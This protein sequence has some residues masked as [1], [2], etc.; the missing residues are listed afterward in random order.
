VHLIESKLNS[1]CAIGN[2]TFVITP[3]NNFSRL[4]F[5]LGK[6]R[7]FGF[8]VNLSIATNLLQPASSIGKLKKT[9]I[10]LIYECYELAENFL[11]VKNSTELDFHV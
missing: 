4:F 11:N 9:L 2:F 7:R 3:Y 5:R 8:E 10:T 6:I 1:Y